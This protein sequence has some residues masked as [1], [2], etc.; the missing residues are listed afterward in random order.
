MAEKTYKSDLKVINIGTQFFYDALVAQDV[1]ATQIDWKPPVKQSAEV[2]DALNKIS[3]PELKEKIEAANDKAVHCIIDSEP[4]LVDILPAGEVIEGLDDYTVIHSGPPIDYENMTMLH[5]RGLVSACR[6]EHW[7]ETDEDAIK[8]IESGKI[9]LLPALNTNT[10]GAGTGIITKSVAMFIIE[11]RRTGKISANFPAEGPNQ[12]GFCGWGLYSEVIADYLRKMKDYFFPV[13]KAAIKQMGGLPIKPILAESFV[14]GDENHTRQSAADLLFDKKILPE[15]FKLE[16]FDRQQILDTLDYIVETPRFFHCIGQ[17]ASRS[18]ML[19][20]INTPYSTMVTA[21][22][23][24]GVTFGIKVAGLGENEWFTAPAPM[25]KGLY[26]STKFT[27]ADQLPWK[28]DSCVVECAGMGGLAACAAPIVMSLRGLKLKDGIALTREMENICISKNPAFS[29]PN[30][31]F[32]FLPVGIDIRKVI[33]TGISP[34][35]HGGMFHREGGLIGAGS[36]RVPMQCF[37]KAIKAFAEKYG[38]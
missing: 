16:G 6:F 36:A 15:L 25:M 5:R 37:E 30:L 19:S 7:A 38:K 12:G 23:G 33:E 24:N 14:M 13:M 35:I 31:D 18:A 26:T 10:V 8:L 11:D 17:G 3:S 9:K 20:A 4:Y 34:E 32:D 29:V 28:G 2:L 21:I 1:K 27:D 22:C